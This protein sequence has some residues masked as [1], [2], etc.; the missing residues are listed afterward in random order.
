[1]INK[2]ILKKVFVPVSAVIAMLGMSA[3]EDENNPTQ[4][5]PASTVTNNSS[6]TT[7]ANTTPEN[8]VIV[9]TT[10][11]AP[12]TTEAPDTLAPE[13]TLPLPD[14]REIE[15]RVVAPDGYEYRP[16]TAEEIANGVPADAWAVIG[17]P[18]T[19]EVTCT[20]PWITG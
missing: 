13:T 6:N 14:C 12:T 19:D 17:H 20:L 11:I 5:A 18:G 7:I 1:M 3:C 16:A 10:T 8:T 9:S 2:E 15:G 4:Q